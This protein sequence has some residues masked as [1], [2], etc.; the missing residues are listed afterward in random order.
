[1]PM[2]M[3]KKESLKNQW[4]MNYCM[5]NVLRVKNQIHFDAI[6]EFF[7]L[8]LILVCFFA[9]SMDITNKMMMMMMM[10]KNQN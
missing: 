4:Q 9:I 1:M 8:P 5:S 7:D 10:M 2:E 6:S 3:A